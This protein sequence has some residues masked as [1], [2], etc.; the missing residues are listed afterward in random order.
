M[1]TEELNEAMRPVTT[2]YNQAVRDIVEEALTEHPDDD[3]ARD[4]FI[5]ESVDGSEWVIYTYR[6][7]I[8]I[9]ISDNS[10]AYL[11]FGIVFPD[12]EIP[13]STVA[14]SAMEADCCELLNAMLRTRES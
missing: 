12:G 9:A 2:A 1:N 13:W 14:Y 6:A 7:Q 11:E 4:I 5:S 8:V 10:D 3:E